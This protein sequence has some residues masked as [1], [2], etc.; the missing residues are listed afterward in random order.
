MMVSEIRL[1]QI[2]KDKFGD[3]VAEEFV[4]AIKQTVDSS[5]TDKQ[6]VFLTKDDKVEILEKL[7]AVE[8]RITLRMFYFWIGQVAVI[9]GLL[10]FFFRFASH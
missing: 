8:T 6:S 1:F 4:D 2:A 3:R 9:A 10:S 7:A 5:F